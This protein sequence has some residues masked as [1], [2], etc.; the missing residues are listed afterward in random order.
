MAA[1]IP[2]NASHL[3]ICTVSI[4]QYCYQLDL[5]HWYP[6]EVISRIAIVISFIAIIINSET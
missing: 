2:C 1:I 5:L 3:N 4:Y 6:W